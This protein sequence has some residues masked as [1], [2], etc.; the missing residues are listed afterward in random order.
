MSIWDGY[1]NIGTRILRC[2]IVNSALRTKLRTGSYTKKGSLTG[3]LFLSLNFI[4]HANVRQ[5]RITSVHFQSSN[6]DHICVKINL[7][8][9]IVN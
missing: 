5:I 9:K 2:H 1:T 7:K 4:K 8:L 6:I 3:G